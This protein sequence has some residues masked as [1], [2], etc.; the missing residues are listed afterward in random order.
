MMEPSCRAGGGSKDR[1]KGLW[2]RVCSKVARLQA[3]RLEKYSVGN[4]KGR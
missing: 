2:K 4:S 1:T 3:C